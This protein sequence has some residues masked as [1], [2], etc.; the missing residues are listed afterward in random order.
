MIRRYGLVQHKKDALELVGACETQFCPVSLGLLNKEQTAM[1]NSRQLHDMAHFLEII[2]NLQYRLS[3]KFKRPGQVMVCCCLILLILVSA[4]CSDIFTRRKVNI[5]HML[6]VDGGEALSVADTTLLQDDAQ[7]SVLSADVVSLN[8]LNRHELCFPV[9][10]LSFNDT[11]KPALMPM[12][13][14]DSKNYLDSKNFSELSALVSQDVVL[15]NA[16]LPMENPREMIARWEIDNLDLTNVVKDALLS[17]RLPLAVLQL[18]L[19][20]L[21]DLVNDR[22]PHD[23]F[24]EVRDIGRAIAYDLFLKVAG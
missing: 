8:N 7:F 12:E 14:L 2:R 4:N 22:E 18:H 11:E 19:H 1:E 20:R 23:T 13:S 3:A 17:G 15:E 10:E 6:Q 9:S 16:V 5:C 24:A 21:R